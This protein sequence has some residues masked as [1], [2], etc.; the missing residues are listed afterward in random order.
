LKGSISNILSQLNNVKNRNKNTWQA[1]CPVH[2]D[3]NPSLTIT[4]TDERILLRCHA[5]C[6]AEDIVEKLGLNMSD[7]F[8]NEPDREGVDKPSESNRTVEQVPQ[9]EAGSKN[10]FE[11]S[12]EVSTQLGCQLEEYAELKN[13]PERFLMEIGLSEITYSGDPA[14]RIPY[15]DTDGNEKSVRFRTALRKG[16]YNDNRFKWRKGSKICL[17]GLNRLSQYNNEEIILVEGESDTHVLW[18]HNEQAIGLPGAGNWNERRDAQ[19]LD[20]FQTIFIVI[21]P[22]NGGDSIK[23]WLETSSIQERVKLIELSDYNDVSDMY[24]DNLDNFTEQWNELKEN[25]TPWTEIKQEKQILQQNEAWEQC[26]HIAKKD[27]ILDYFYETLESL[28][29]VGEER[30]AKILYLAVTSRILDKPINVAVKGPSS[31]GK[32][33]IVEQVLKFFPEFAYHA[34]SAMSERALIYSD[35]PLQHRMLV[36]YEAAG[37]GGEFA[38]Y[39]LRTLLSERRVQYSTVEKTTE[40]LKQRHIIREGPTGLIT[41]TTAPSLHSENETRILS[42]QITDTNEQTSAIMIALAEENKE[43]IDF[44]PWHAFQRW[45]QMGE[46]R[47]VI[48]YAKSLAKKIPAVAVRLRRDF[49]MVL[50]LIKAHTIIHRNLRDKNESGKIKATLEDYK[51]IRRLVNSTIQQ[52]IESGVSEVIRETVEAVENYDS[53]GNLTVTKLAEILDIAKA[54]IVIGDPLPEEQRLLPTVDELEDSSTVRNEIEV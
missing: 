9:N 3:T 39:L 7:L 5:G 35:E 40:G 1:L 21:E 48:P 29:V 30:N 32:S 16:E 49:G 51:V 41:T 20:Q 47:V 18:Y 37:I 17:Y 45:L 8:V 43:E 13:I 44:V 52:E 22:D 42:L 31:G 24:V 25:A 34:L 6:L 46:T 14:V 2:D 12:D 38:T 19:H 53:E 11:E 23:E 54:N 28:N 10:K 27:N 26:K 15:H 4:V 36:V 50:R 33:F